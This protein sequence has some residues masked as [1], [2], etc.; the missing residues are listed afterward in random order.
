[1]CV[2]SENWMEQNLLKLNDEKSE[3]VLFVPKHRQHQYHDISLKIGDCRVMPS[4]SA[5]NLGVM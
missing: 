2:R 3:L 4:T 1:M 5:K